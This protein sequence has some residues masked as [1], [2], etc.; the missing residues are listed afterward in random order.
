M[1][2]KKAAAAMCAI[3]LAFATSLPMAAFAAESDAAQDTQTEVVNVAD[4]QS[5]KDAKASANKA[6]STPKTGDPT[7]V[8]IPAAIAVAAAGALVAAKA[9]RE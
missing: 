6:A 4:Q 9:M 8:I 1:M 2:R 7:N 3:A 5:G